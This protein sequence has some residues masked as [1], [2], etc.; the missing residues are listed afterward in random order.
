MLIVRLC[1]SDNNVYPVVEA[2]VNVTSSSPSQLRTTNTLTRTI[3]LPKNA[4]HIKK[5]QVALLSF[6]SQQRL[7]SSFAIFLSFFL[8]RNTESEL[9]TSKAFTPQERQLVGPKKDKYT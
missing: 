1:D 7:V 9:P 6:P 8:L 5:P 3:A 4:I 2:P